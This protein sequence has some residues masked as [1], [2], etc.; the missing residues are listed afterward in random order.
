V[1]RILG[2]SLRAF[3][4]ALEER[5]RI[6]RARSEIASEAEPC[7]S[8]RLASAVMHSLAVRARADEKRAILEG[9]AEAGV[10]MICSR[11]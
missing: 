9:L 11:R 1:R 10:R 8:P 7:C 2:H 6:A 4:R 3:D 5:F